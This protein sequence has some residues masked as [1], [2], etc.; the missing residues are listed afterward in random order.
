MALHVPAHHAGVTGD[1]LFRNFLIAVGIAI[2]LIVVVGVA[3]TV[4]VNVVTTGTPVEEV[5]S[6]IQYRAAERADWVVGVP[7]QASSLIDF[8]AAEREGR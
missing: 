4:R 8:R 3:M 2:A 1:H 6:L 7:T 5:Q